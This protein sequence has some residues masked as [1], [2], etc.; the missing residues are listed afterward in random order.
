MWFVDRFGAATYLDGSTW[1]LPGRCF[2]HENISYLSC[3]ARPWP[4]DR[5]LV[6]A[7]GKSHM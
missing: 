6:T 2:L 4:F 3:L 7:G 5:G 1:N